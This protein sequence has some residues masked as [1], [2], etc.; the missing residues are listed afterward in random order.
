VEPEPSRLAAARAATL[1]STLAA[2]LC[3][4]AAQGCPAG[5]PAGP[6]QAVDPLWEIGLFNFVSDI[7]HYP[8]SDESQV[9]AFPMPYILYRGERL[10]ATR[11]GVRGIF[12]RDE[13]L[14]TS[15]SLS[16]NP[17]VDNDNQARAGMPDL[18]AVGEIGPSLKWLLPQ[19][20]P[21]DQLYLLGS[22]RAAASVAV[23]SGPQVAYRGLAG[24][25]G[26]VYSNRSSLSDRRL[27]FRIGAGINLGD[28]GYHGYFYDVAPQYATPGRPAYSAEGG[29]G[30]TYLSFTMQYDLSPALALG[31]YSRWDS[32]GGAVFA[33]SP[34]VRQD[35][36]FT[37]G[38][39]LIVRLLHSQQQVPA[40]RLD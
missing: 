17:P 29:Y 6:P 22:I 38:A 36:N 35:D 13:R 30:G 23:E 39:A 31:F 18:D 19:R 32:V 16:G 8:G 11:E 20:D 4:A 10:R 14:E 3:L 5:E 37:I 2:A 24:A 40:G 9:Y 7:P 28:R 33:D 34:L 26:A 15:I 21:R 12:Y 27:R 1:G 25:L